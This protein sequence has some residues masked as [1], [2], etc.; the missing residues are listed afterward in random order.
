MSYAK[1]AD[2]EPT[3]PERAIPKELPNLLAELDHNSRQINAFAHKSFTNR[4]AEQR[5]LHF[6]FALAAWRVRDLR[7]HKLFEKL[8]GCYL[9]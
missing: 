6:P 4:G 5:C 7:L 8:E 3:R 1:G 9:R 2:S